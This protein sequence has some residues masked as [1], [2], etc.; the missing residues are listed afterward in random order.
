[1]LGLDAIREA[2]HRIHPIAHRTPVLTSHLFDK[3]AG[4]ECH[5]KCENFQRGGA[6]KI[7]GAAN[8]LL[9]LE[10]DKRRH[11]VVAFSSGNHAQAVA[12]AAAYC[13]TQATIVM[14]TD[15]PA[16]KLRAT[17]AYGATVVLYDRLTEDR[18]ALG[19]QLAEETGATLV[20]PYDH[21]WIIAGQ[22]TAALEL[23]EERPDLE[24]IV[25][26]VGGG[27]LLSGS[28]IAAKSIRPEIRV[29]GVEP[30]L[31]NDTWLSWRAGHRVEIAPSET[32]ADGLRATK[33]GAVTFPIVKQLADDILLVSEEE[34]R[35][36]MDFL[37]SRLKI[38]VEPSGAVPAAALLSGKLPGGFKKVGVIVS[39][40]NL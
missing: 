34:I 28:A 35:A 40:G 19:R 18:E 15:A 33:P 36:A 8:F 9:S 17:R 7:R 13:G 23:L 5:F 25:T 27:G 31:A 2:A 11:G 32:I 20:P 10:E 29:F 3:A 30:E 12:I 22:G 6:F 21:P 4:V 14:P 26:C 39:G 37:N 38:V 1:M 16:V 24:A